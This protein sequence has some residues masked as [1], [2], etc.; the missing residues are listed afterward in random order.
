[1]KGRLVL[2]AGT[3]TQTVATGDGEQEAVGPAYS[4]LTGGTVVFNG[5][6]KVEGTGEPDPENAKTYP[7]YRFGYNVERPSESSPLPSG[8]QPGDS[9][10]PCYVYNENSGQWEWVG[11][12]QSHA[13]RATA[14]SARCVPATS[15]RR[16]TWTA[17]TALSAC[18]RGRGCAVER[19]ECRRKRHL[20]AR[21]HHHGLH[22]AVFRSAR[23]Y[24]YA[25]KAGHGWPR[26]ARAPI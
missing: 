5:Q 23:G 14:S 22:R 15:G 17:S 8:V 7:A 25:G 21:G 12:G 10:S 18:R 16:L 26:S 2:R 19:D 3:G 9:G 4:Y 1:M 24:L 20:R 13:E 6:T 11:A